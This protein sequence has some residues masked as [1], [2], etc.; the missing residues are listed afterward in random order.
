ME[1][2]RVPGD[3]NRVEVRLDAEAY[4]RLQELASSRKWPLATVLREA[5]DHLHRELE[6]EHKLKA[7]ERLA[8]L[9]L[10]VPPPRAS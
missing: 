8:S 5:V 4:A 6:K 10:P 3:R 9:R 1:R 2:R 7:V